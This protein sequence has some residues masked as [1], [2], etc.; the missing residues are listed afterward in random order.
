M[1]LP[2]YSTF[3]ETEVRMDVLSTI[4]KDPLIF[5]SK[6][7]RQFT[8]LVV[9]PL[10]ICPSNNQFTQYCTHFLIMIDGLE[11]CIDRASQM[12]IS[13]GLADSMRDFNP[14]TQI[15]ATGPKHDVDLSFIS[16]NLKEI[17]TSLWLGVDTGYEA[18]TNIKLYLCERFP[19]T[20]DDFDNRTY[21]RKLDP[22][23]PGLKAIDCWSETLRVNLFTQQRSF[24]MWNPPVIALTAA[25]LD[26]VYSPRPHDRHGPFSP[27]AALSYF[28]QAP[29]STPCCKL[30]YCLSWLGILWALD[31][32][33]D[34]IR[35]TETKIPRLPEELTMHI[36]LED[37]SNGEET[38]G[39][40]FS[41]RSRL[42]VMKFM[43]FNRI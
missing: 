42:D 10:R 18:G 35:A 43:K 8:A 24:D 19:P 39:V 11:E 20:Q 2:P 21:G 29:P 27:L 41:A 14:F 32:G 4:K 34:T 26:M 5:K 3:P 25:H 9:Q 22:S 6:A 33:D 13:I 17:P 12:A 31:A 28:A 30:D 15:V 16:R 38:P 1:E 36:S 40:S 7:R 23:W 37:L